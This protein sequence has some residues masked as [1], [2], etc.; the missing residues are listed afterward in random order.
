[1]LGQKLTVVK[2]ES[3]PKLF[4]YMDWRAEQP[5]FHRVRAVF[6]PAELRR[7]VH[8]SVQCPYLEN[9]DLGQTGHFHKE[10]V[11]LTVLCVCLT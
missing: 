4:S 3:A 7:Q 9:T 1:M 5:S 8:T 11:E 6:L 2:I 10:A